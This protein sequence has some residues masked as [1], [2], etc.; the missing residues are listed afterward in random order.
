MKQLLSLFFLCCAFF[1]NAQRGAITPD[2]LHFFQAQ[3]PNAAAVKAI[4]N[5]LAHSSINQLAETTT[6]DNP[7]LEDLH[8]SNTVKSKGITD[9]HSSGRCWLFTSFNMMRADAIQKYNLGEFQFSQS[10][11]FFFDQLEKANLFLQSIIDRAN[12]PI[13]SRTNAW[14]FQHPL[15]DGG[16]FA[17]AQ[18]LVMKYGAV[19][20]SVFPESYSS[21]NTKLMDMITKLKL[22]EFALQ[23]RQMVADKVPTQKIE[24]QK[25]KQLAEIY[26]I[27]EICLGT[28]PEKFTYTLRSA[29]GKVISTKEYTP[30]EFYQTLFGKDLHRSYVMLMN[31]PTRPYYR[32]YT[33]DLD[34]HTYD[35]K[36][37]TYINLPMD[38]IKKIAIRSIKDNTMM[39]MSCDV[40]KFL[41]AKTGVLSLQNYDYESLFD[42]SFPMTKAQRIQT[43]AS[44]SSH[45]MTMMGVDLNAQGQPIK[46]MVENSWGPTHGY[47]GHL[48][49]TDEWLNEY[50]FRLVAEK[51]FVDDNILK[52]LEQKPT[53]LPA[54]D[55]LF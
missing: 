28:P 13:D 18:D 27:L 31:D 19:P 2:M 15:S 29:D 20:T 48:I 55:P 25:L 23:L 43:Y 1:A 47:K 50:L 22:R 35:G 11:S 41:N 8:F 7:V 44:A 21:N 33:V 4:K 38:E 46:W 51:R 39:Y 17:G 10:Y 26:H 52:I 12:E 34:R 14:L 32:L 3:K 54:W 30:K 49:M 45:A 6:A 40:G 42:T 37:W 36:D 24:Q 16:T 9:Q 5:A 53:V